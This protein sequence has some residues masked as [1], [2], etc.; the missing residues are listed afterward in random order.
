MEDRLRVGVITSPHGIKGEVKVFS[1]TDD[2]KRF[3]DLKK[4][5]LSCG[6]KLFEV[7]CTSCKFLKNMAV[8]KFA[9]YDKIEDVEPLRNWDILVNREDAVKLD[10][11]EFF[12][13]DI[14][15]AT[16]L[17][18]NDHEIGIIDD[19]LETPAQHILVVRGEAKEPIYI[20][21]VREWVT[22]I[23]LENK[24]VKVCLLKI[25]EDV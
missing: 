14:L 7:E 5:F 18:Q 4:C 17:D 13:C 24:I 11:G 21:V 25:A 3:K 10:E 20:P 12:L 8:L 1:T 15:S 2:L 23:D 19:V 9:G 6:E 16:V 22:D